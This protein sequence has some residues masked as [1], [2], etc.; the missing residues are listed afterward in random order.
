MTQ[1][2]VRALMRLTSSPPNGPLQPRRRVSADV[3]WKRLLGLTLM[4]ICSDYAPR[5]RFL[6]QPSCK[7]SD[8][9]Q[10]CLLIQYQ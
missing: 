9:G 7:S 4:F 5:H 6:A 1:G 10:P 3:G 2:L 8:G